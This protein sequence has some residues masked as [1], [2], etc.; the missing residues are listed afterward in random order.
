MLGTINKSI[1][2]CEPLLSFDRIA[3]T[4]FVMFSDVSFNPLIKC[5]YLKHSARNSENFTSYKRSLLSIQ[6][7]V[8][9]RRVSSPFTLNEISFEATS[10]SS[11]GSFSA[12]PLFPSRNP[13]HNRYELQNG[14]S[15][16]LSQIPFVI[17]QKYEVE[18]IIG[19]GNFAVVYACVNRVTKAEYALKVIDKNKCKG[20]EHMIESEVAILRR[21][22]H[23]NIVQLVEEFDFENDL[24]L[25]M[26][27]V[28]GG[29]LFDAIA[30]ATKY[31]EKDASLMVHDLSSALCYL[32]SLN[33]VHRDIKPENL[34]VVEHEDGSRSLKLGDF[35][36]AVEAKEPLF[37]VCGTPTYVAPEILAETG[38][39]LK[40]DVWAAGV[41]T[42]ILLCGF[43]PFVSQTNDQVELFDQILAGNYEFTR[44]FWDDISDSAKEL[45]AMMLQVN[46]DDRY[47]AADVLEHPWV[48]ADI[49]HDTDMQSAVSREITMHFKPK[50]S[51]KSAGIALIAETAIDKWT[52][53][54]QTYR[55]KNY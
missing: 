29:D 53:N 23:V 46:P 26:E 9:R 35:G 40:V 48:L 41:I 6:S 15:F 11:R 44:P 20:K 16:S 10:N 12:S 34:L 45:I 42:Y 1:S 49:A 37:T 2:Q 52:D 5:K 17:S 4:L 31:T 18:K 32:H 24:Y 13:I 27:L 30:S 43:P 3:E 22:K 50:S 55:C 28:K 54:F 8:S 7:P 21:V 25:V 19:D 38:Y 36:L 39:G 14:H 47:S 33:I 51:L